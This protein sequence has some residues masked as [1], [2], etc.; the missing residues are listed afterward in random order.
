M[1]KF[2]DVELPLSVFQKKNC[3]TPVGYLN[4]STHFY[5][6]GESLTISQN[7][8]DKGA[9]TV[10]KG[11]GNNGLPNKGC[12]P[13]E[14][15]FREGVAANG[16]YHWEYFDGTDWVLI[17]FI[18][19]GGSNI[20]LDTDNPSCTLYKKEGTAFTDVGTMRICNEVGELHLYVRISNTGDSNVDWFFLKTL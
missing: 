17:N 18:P 19:R 20:T 1:V 14:G 5:W 4:L 8:K 11:V 13:Q 3:N 15:D 10:K 9:W 7:T 6:K 12:E 2:Y 16:N